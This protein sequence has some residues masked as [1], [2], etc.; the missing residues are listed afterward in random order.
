ME[1]SPRFM[2]KE[3][4][5]YLGYKYY[6]RPPSRF[7]ESVVRHFSQQE[8]DFRPPAGFVSESRITLSAA[9]DLMPYEWIVPEATTH[10]WD[11]TGAFF[12]SSDLVFA[13]LETPIDLQKPP[14]LVPEVMLSDMLFNGSAEMFDIFSGQSGSQPKQRGYDMVSTANNHSLD[15]GEQGI[16]H[17][18]DFLESRGVACTGTARNAG[19]AENF[20]ILERQGIRVAFLA[21]TYS[22]NQFEPPAGKEWLV[23]YLRLNKPGCPIDP[24]I[25]QVRQ[26]RPAR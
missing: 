21:Y 6:Y 24:I 26:A 8:L 1:E 18:I 10:L 22:L 23:N 2:G 25:R 5:L 16:R 20:P 3:E 4:V 12:F 7:E 9:G 15:M 19:E 13:N 11:E 17:T 14:S